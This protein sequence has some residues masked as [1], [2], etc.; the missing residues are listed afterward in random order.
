[1]DESV[2]L[3]YAIS[4]P[5]R[6]WSVAAIIALVLGLLSGPIAF[7]LVRLCGIAY[8]ISIVGGVCVAIVG[9]PT[10]GYCLW[11]SGRRD[12]RTRGRVLG[13]IGLI[14]TLLWSVGLVALF[15]YID[16]HLE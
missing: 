7:V 2:Q 13:F 4:R 5:H 8:G 9:I 14:A 6:P 3:D 1:M 15:C 12:E 11:A 10:F 16:A